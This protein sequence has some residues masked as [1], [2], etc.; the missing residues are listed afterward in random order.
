M[1]LGLTRSS[2]EH[3]VDFQNISVLQEIRH[4]FNFS[5]NQHLCSPKVSPCGAIFDSVLPVN[6]AYYGSPPKTLKLTPPELLRYAGWPSK[7]LSFYECINE[8]SKL[9]IS[10]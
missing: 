5:L 8:V 6:K 3:C 2:H 7:I 1:V 4:S 9:C 10:I